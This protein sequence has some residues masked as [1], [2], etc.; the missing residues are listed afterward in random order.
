MTE[1]KFRS[2]P[3]WSVEYHGI[4]YDDAREAY[5]MWFYRDILTG[6][7]RPF[8]SNRIVKLCRNDV[9]RSVAEGNVVLDT[10]PDRDRAVKVTTGSSL[11]AGAS[12]NHPAQTTEQL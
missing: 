12:G 2:L 9:T 5:G 8:K 10:A 3:S 1:A 7:I 4:A 11:G 6:E